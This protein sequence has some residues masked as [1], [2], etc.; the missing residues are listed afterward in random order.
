[1]EIKTFE[2]EAKNRKKL[3]HG[4]TLAGVASR[5]EAKREFSEKILVRREIT[6]M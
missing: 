1:M 4:A 5:R 3:P 2:N 6:R